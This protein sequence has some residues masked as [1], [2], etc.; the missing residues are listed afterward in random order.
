MLPI[1]PCTIQCT[2][3]GFARSQG[4]IFEGVTFTAKPSE[5]LMVRGGNGSGKTSLLRVLAGLS[6]AEEGSISFQLG[7]SE[8]EEGPA[9]GHMDWLGHGNAMKPGLTAL[10]NLQFWA[11]AAC[12]PEA[13]VTALEKSGLAGFEHRQQQTLSAGQCRRLALSRLWLSANP[14]WY[15]DEPSS[16]LD[17]R[18]VQLVENLLDA[19]C[20]RGGT[21]IVATHDMVHPKAPVSYLKLEAGVWV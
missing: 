11:D 17:T 12:A 16:N 14:V 1:T 18:G 13:V 2:G 20:S 9:R 5:V 10:Q 6:R 8:P 3:L 4:M 15:L 19:H 21:A 7:E